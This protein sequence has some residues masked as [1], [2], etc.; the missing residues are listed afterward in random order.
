MLTAEDELVIRKELSVKVSQACPATQIIPAPIYFKEKA[1]YFA[2]IEN[3]SNTQKL[4]ETDQIDMCVISLLRFVDSENEGCPNEPLVR[5]TYNLYFF[6]S[7]DFER[8]DE[9]LTPDVF[10]KQTLLSYNAFIKN[11]LDARNEF[12]GL[13]AVP[14]LPSGFDVKTNSLIQDEN[15]SDLE[16]CRFIPAE[17]GHS[18]DISVTL[19]VLVNE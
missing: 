15:I 9:S 8:E 19:E 3:L 5:L 12:L 14:G 17:N 13:Q 6:R 7:Y 2:N 16:E 11:I 18:V 4:I 10:L 1:D